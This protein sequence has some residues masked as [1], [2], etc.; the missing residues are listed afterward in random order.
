M[1]KSDRPFLAMLNYLDRPDSAD[2]FVALVIDDTPAGEVRIGGYEVCRATSD[3]G[4]LANLKGRDAARMAAETVVGSFLQDDHEEA[5]KAAAALCHFAQNSYLVVHAALGDDHE[6]TTISLKAIRAP[7][8]ESATDLL[9][10]YA[11]AVRK[12]LRNAPH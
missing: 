7:D 2:A 5:L 8:F 6:I 10:D 3:L 9:Q 1:N 11:M 12:E 4:E